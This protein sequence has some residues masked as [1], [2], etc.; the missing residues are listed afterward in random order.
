VSLQ[1]DNRI[2]LASIRQHRTAPATDELC[3]G[4]RLCNRLLNANITAQAV[5]ALSHHG[6]VAQN[7][8]GVRVPYAAAMT[9]GHTAAELAGKGPAASEMAGLWMNIKS[10]LHANMKIN[11]VKAHA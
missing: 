7:I 3:S 5:A 11:K 4:R 1:S 8:I 6:L 10:C 9:D 2:V